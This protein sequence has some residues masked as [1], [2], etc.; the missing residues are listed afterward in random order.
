MDGLPYERDAELAD[1]I[2]EAIA[3]HKRDRN[4]RD[5]VLADRLDAHANRIHDMAAELRG[6][7]GG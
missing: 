3:A 6:R 4:E 7:N 2:R 1:V 5:V